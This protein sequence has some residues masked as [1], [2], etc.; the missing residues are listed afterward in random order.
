VFLLREKSQREK[1]IV[2]KEGEKMAHY[3]WVRFNGEVLYQVGIEP[4]GSL[5]NPRNYPEAIVRAAIVQAEERR[6]KR[7][8]ASAAKATITRKR[9]HDMRVQL[10]AKRIVEGQA[11][12]PRATCYICGRAITDDDSVRRGIGSECWQSLLSAIERQK[13]AVP[14]NGRGI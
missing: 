5:F 7:H 8:K 3:K 1:R 9:R 2:K 11:I 12:G 10:A 4:D 13:Q 14:V 6:K